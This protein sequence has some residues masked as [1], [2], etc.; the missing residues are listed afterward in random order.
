[1]NRSK[2]RF[3]TGIQPTGTLTLGH[4]FGVIQHILAIQEEYEIIIMICDL[5]ALTIPKKDFDYQKTRQ[6]I[7][8]LLYACGL[9]EDCKIYFQ[10]Q[11]KAHLE[12][13]WLLSPFV[14]ISELSNM[15]QYKE[16]K[17]DQET[18]N[19]AL[20]GYP[21][22]MAADIFLFDADLIIVGQD[23]KQHL[24]LATGIAQKF[25]NFYETNLLK[26]PQFTI[27]KFGAK[28]MGLKNPHKKMSKSEQDCI[29]LLDSFETIEKKI[30]TAETDSENKIYYDPE[31]KF[32]I[33]NLLTIYTL[34]S[35]KEIK[36]AEKELENT[37]YHQFKLKLIELL[38]NELKNIQSRHQY[39]LNK[40]EE[41]TK[42]NTDYLKKISSKKIEIIKKELKI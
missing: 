35:N 41:I 16:K 42:K 18:G 27:P 1:M 37:N 29:F 30:K 14:T 8:A 6:E 32:G 19:L 11:I 3:F 15:I 17:K 9:K 12:L 7:T 20:L 40:V 33:S 21:V 2:L 36:E 28:I 26:V 10:S 39:Y 22:L 13:N 25:D 34:L 4:Y 38:S 31:K 23:Q 24:E 5:H